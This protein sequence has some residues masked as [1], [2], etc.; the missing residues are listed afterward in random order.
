MIA[1]TNDLRPGLHRV[2]EDL[3]SHY[4]LAY[5][6]EIG[7]YDGHFRTIAVTVRLPDV[8][9][10]TR[11]G[12]YALP[13]I[14]GQAVL[15]FEV[16][17][18]NAL[19]AAT[20]PHDIVFRSAGLHFRDDTVAVVID[21]PLPGIGFIRDELNHEY[22]THL[23]VLALIKDAQG[24]VVRK[25]SRDIPVRGPLDRLDTSALGRFIYT[26]HA[27]LSPGRYT[28]ETAIIDRTTEQISANKSSILIT[29]A[30]EDLGIS[31]LVRVRNFAPR[32]AN[33]PEPRS[34][35]PFQIPAG[36][37]SPELEDTVQGGPHSTVS[38][39]FSVYVPAGSQTVPD[40]GID[41]LQDGKRIGHEAPKL[42]APDQRGIIPCIA[43]MPLGSF[44][45]GQYQVQVTVR[46]D[47]KTATEQTLVTIE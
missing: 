34:G 32:D 28:L 40:L 10:E 39:F 19:A 41:F 5:S 31:S 47:N 22:H 13:F 8:R 45:P 42:Q 20:L 27:S 46:Q 15:P 17:L 12:Y 43:T 3:D 18:L 37:I 26:Q 29:P 30:S 24:S 2:T 4:E 16:P 23:S 11:G 35:D 36:K 14:P 44:K 21:V 9:V 25:F 1:D 38:Y 6:P 33:E 7:V